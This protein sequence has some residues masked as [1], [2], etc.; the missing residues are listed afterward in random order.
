MLTTHAPSTAHLKSPQHWGDLGGPYSAIA[1]PTPS[2][3]RPKS[4]IHGG[5]RGPCPSPYPAP[6]GEEEEE[7]KRQNKPTFGA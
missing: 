7:L 2:T 1:T 4:P 6:R 3:T 5:F